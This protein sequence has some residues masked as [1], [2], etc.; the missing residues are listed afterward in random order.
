MLASS[1]GKSAET[2]VSEESTHSEHALTFAAVAD[3]PDAH[4][5]GVTTTAVPTAPTSAKV[6][7]WIRAELNEADR[8]GSEEI[9]ELYR[10]LRRYAAML[11]CAS[12]SKS[13]RR[14]L[15]IDVVSNLTI[16]LC[17]QLS[18]S[19]ALPELTCRQQAAATPARYVARLIGL[20]LKLAFRKWASIVCSPGAYAEGGAISWP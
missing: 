5:I 17:K 11:L 10:R 1:D 15:G 16:S 3:V 12:A 6:S 13:M 19:Q 9:F 4:R 20:D 18:Q 2:L 14:R 7:T 8:F